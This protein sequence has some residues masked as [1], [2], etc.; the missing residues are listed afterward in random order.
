[1]KNRLTLF[2]ISAT[3]DGADAQTYTQAQRFYRALSHGLTIYSRL[4]IILNQLHYNRSTT[5]ERVTSHH[6][7]ATLADVTRCAS[8]SDFRRGAETSATKHFGTKCKPNDRLSWCRSVSSELFWVRSVLVPSEVSA[9]IHAPNVHNDPRFN[10][11]F[12]LHFGFNKTP[13]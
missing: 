3:L 7:T 11:Y 10:H 5:L 13:R 8:G 12:H 1:V 4:I 9:F 2:K 6:S